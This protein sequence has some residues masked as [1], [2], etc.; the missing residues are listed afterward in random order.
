MNRIIA[1]LI[2]LAL[3]AC[4]AGADIAAAETAATSFHAALNAQDFDEIYRSTTPEFKTAGP[5]ESFLGLLTAVSRKLGKVKTFNRVGFN[6]GA[7]PAGRFVTLRYSS[8]FE[9]GIGQETFTYR[10]VGE[11]AVLNGYNIATPALTVRYE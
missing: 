5:K 6:V 1:T 9:R 3:G 7:V 11:T 2:A 10:M 8:V 4:S